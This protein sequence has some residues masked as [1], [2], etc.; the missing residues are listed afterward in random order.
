MSEGTANALGSILTDTDKNALPAMMERLNAA[1]RAQAVAEII[2]K[3][4]V[5]GA[6][7]AGAATAQPAP[8]A[9]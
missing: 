9:S 7:Q 8:G 4:T 5:T 6:A 2:R 1:H 3:M